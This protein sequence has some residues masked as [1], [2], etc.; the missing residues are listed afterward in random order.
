VSLRAMLWAFDEAP[1]Y[2]S[3]IQRHVLVALADHV[4]DSTQIAWPSIARLARRTGLGQS[5]VRRSLAALADAGIISVE[6]HGAP[7]KG[8][9]W[10]R[11]NLYRWHPDGSTQAVD[12]S[13]D[14]PPTAVTPPTAAGGPPS[15]CE[16][17]PPPAVTPEQSL[18]PLE[19]R[20]CPEV[21]NQDGRPVD[22][23]ALRRQLRA[24]PRP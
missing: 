1:P 16:G 10:T 20:S 11:P 12:K 4:D 14:K 5:T 24:V 19:N 18:E 9:D 17:G 22:T 6:I 8:G 13:V 7:T 2:L 21:P 3:P 15:R 23:A